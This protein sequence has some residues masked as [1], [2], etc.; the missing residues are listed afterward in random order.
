MWLIIEETRSGE[1]VVSRRLAPRETLDPDHHM[2]RYLDRLSSDSGYGFRIAESEG[3]IPSGCGE[4]RVEIR[5]RKHDGVVIWDS[6]DYF[7]ECE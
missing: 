6:G 5:R 7:T 1:H 4:I 2:Q 3:R